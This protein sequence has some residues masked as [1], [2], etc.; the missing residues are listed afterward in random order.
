MKGYPATANTG[1]YHRK[2]G[3]LTITA[4]SDGYMDGPID[5]ARNLDPQTTSAMLHE[6]FR[7]VPPR[8]SINTF[9]IRSDTHTALVDTGSGDTM[10]PTMGRLIEN[11]N[12]IGIESED[13]DTVLLT[14]MHP[15]HS[16]GLLAKDGGRAFP[17]A[18][19]AVSE[20]DVRH[21]HDDTAMAAATE[22]QKFRYFQQAREQIAPYKDRLVDPGDAVS[23]IDAIP[24][25]GHTPGHTCYLVHSGSEAILIWGDT[26]HWPAVQVPR[27][28]ITMHYDTD[29]DSAAA[30]RKLIFDMAASERLLVGGMHTDF[31]GFGYVARQGAS[32]T[33][34]SDVWAFTP[35]V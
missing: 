31:P 1:I 23:W 16:N 6:A 15:D 14:H 9:L 17:N 7:L 2:V 35:S 5:A 12:S 4:V 20:I 19:I 32:F 25:P 22:R 26:V 8:V 33:Y 24:T 28:E 13:V 27:P 30:S 29:P 21:W 18:Q 34:T 3:D 11:L 10:G